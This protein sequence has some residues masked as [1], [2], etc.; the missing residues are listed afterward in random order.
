MR[1][2]RQRLKAAREKELKRA[3]IQRNASV[4]ALQSQLAQLIASLETLRSEQRA[5]RAAL[6]AEK[7]AKPAA[8]SYDRSPDLR[9]PKN[10]IMAANAMTPR[11]LE[12]VNYQL[13]VMLGGCYH[14]PY[15]TKAVFPMMSPVNPVPA[16]Q[17]YPQYYQQ[18]PAMYG[19]G[20]FN[21][22][23]TED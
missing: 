13:E 6:P 17:M 2:A 21:K 9:D 8:E 15:P 22:G 5:L 10:F 16:G 23:S 7:P 11:Q 1:I 14:K 18:Y 20:G 12:W 3:E 19:F 4:C